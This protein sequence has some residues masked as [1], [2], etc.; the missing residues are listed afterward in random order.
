M[1]AEKKS[2]YK[3]LY[4]K[5]LVYTSLRVFGCRCYPYLR[6]YASNKF[7]PKSLHCAFLGYNEKYKGHRCLHP[8]S[9]K[10]YI[11]RHAIFDEIQFSYTD[12]FRIF[13]PK[14]STPLLCAWQSGFTESPQDTTIQAVSITPGGD[15]IECIAGSDPVPI[16]TNYSPPPKILTHLQTTHL[17]LFKT[18]LSLHLQKNL[19]LNPLT[20]VLMTSLLCFHQ[21]TTLQ[22]LKFSTLQWMPNQSNL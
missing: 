9:G 16:G 1:L 12:V 4:H 2:L 10:V 20:S 22:W 5:E 3:I 13:L 18:L 11:T 8:P 21:L 19:H 6:P 7:D 14:A 15:K 17:K